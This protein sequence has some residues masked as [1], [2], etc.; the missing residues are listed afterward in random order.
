MITAK[1]VYLRSAYVVGCSMN[2]IPHGFVS[3]VLVIR[4]SPLSVLCNLIPQ[5]HVVKCY[6]VVHLDQLLHL[7]HSLHRQ[8]HHLAQVRMFDPTDTCCKV[9]Q[10]G[11]LGPVTT[12]SSLFA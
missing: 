8:H 11:L 12:L 10:C 2:D 4:M 1:M 3:D 5:T 9:L 6:N 7:L